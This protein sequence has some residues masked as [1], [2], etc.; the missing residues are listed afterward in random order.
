MKKVGMI[1]IQRKPN[2]ITVISKNKSS[3][4]AIVN[5]ASYLKFVSKK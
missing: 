2:T 1:T 5:T 4:Q 3:T